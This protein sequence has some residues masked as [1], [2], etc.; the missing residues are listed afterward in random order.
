MASEHW[1]SLDEYEQLKRK[2][3]RRLV[4][5]SAMVVVAGLIFGKAVNSGDSEPAAKAEASDA[6]AVAQQNQPAE[7]KEKKIV[8]QNVVLV[9][10]EDTNPPPQAQ[11]EKTA[12]KTGSNKVYDLADGQESVELKDDEGTVRTVTQQADPAAQQDPK[13]E[14]M[15]PAPMIVIENTNKAAAARER[16]QKEKQAAQAKAAAE[17]KRLAEQRAAAEKAAAD[18]QQAQKQ[19]AEA[20][21]AAA[22]ERAA[23]AKTDAA[24]AKKTAEA[25]HLAAQKK[26]VDAKKAE[27]DRLAAQKKQAA[28]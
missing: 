1:N 20:D 2:N 11:I 18:K 14:D 12:A 15:I 16:E 6:A 8:K 24:Q 22:A 27:A 28:D 25:E 23:K 9:G 13:P 3:R 21:K 17:K 7:T 10:P 19:R 4:G 26:Q 5:A